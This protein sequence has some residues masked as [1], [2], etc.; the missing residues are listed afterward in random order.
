[1]TAQRTLLVARSLI[2]ALVVG[3]DGKRLGHVI[4]LEVDP[5]RDFRVSAVELGRFGW[6]DRLHLTRPITRG[7]STQ[8]LR[9]VAWHD[10]DRLDGGRL[11]CRP[12]TK[13]REEIPIDDDPTSQQTAPGG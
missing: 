13:V 2:G 6:L 10:I 7:R 1:M 11:I 9:I 12:G 4:D 8:P 5:E 3:A